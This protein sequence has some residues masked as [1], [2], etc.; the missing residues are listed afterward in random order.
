MVDEDTRNF[1]Y[2]RE[3]CNKLIFLDNI[4]KTYI[5]DYNQQDPNGMLDLIKTYEVK[6]RLNNPTKLSYTNDDL[7]NKV[8]TQPEYKTNTYNL[9]AQ[10]Y[11][12]TIKF[13]EETLLTV[14]MFFGETALLDASNIKELNITANLEITY[15]DEYT[16]VDA[17]KDK[18]TIPI[19]VT[20]K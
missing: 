2:Q 18:I 17:S 9:V 6:N 14:D 13:E 8:L 5:P 10:T 3:Y 20:I 16:G 19:N 11:T 12:D 7:R 4:I 1:L 15:Y